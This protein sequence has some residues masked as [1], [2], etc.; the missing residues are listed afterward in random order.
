[1]SPTES[2]N[3]FHDPLEAW[4]RLLSRFE[5]KGVVIGGIAVSLLGQ[6]RFTED[7]D[8]RERVHDWVIQFADLLEM[9]ELW[10]D[11]AGWL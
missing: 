1:M 5:H 8:A 6:A 4:G 2:N 3:L 9:P 10:E 11:I 7:L